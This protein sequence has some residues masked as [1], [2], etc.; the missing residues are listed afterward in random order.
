MF[1][2]YNM[3]HL[4]KDEAN[5]VMNVKADEFILDNYGDRRNAHMNISTKGTLGDND[6][7]LKKTNQ[8]HL[9]TIKKHLE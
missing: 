2:I 4:S 5:K 8:K 1:G 9:N 6:V 7:Y 3:S